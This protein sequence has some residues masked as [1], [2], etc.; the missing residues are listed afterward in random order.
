MG[1]AVAESWQVLLHKCFMNDFAQRSCVERP[2]DMPT[3]DAFMLYFR[4]LSGALQKEQDTCL[5]K[6]LGLY[7]V[8]LHSTESPASLHTRL[9]IILASAIPNSVELL[10]PCTGKD[11]PSKS[12][13]ESVIATTGIECCTSCMPSALQADIGFLAMCNLV[14]V[15][16]LDKFYFLL[17]WSRDCST[18]ILSVSHHCLRWSVLASQSLIFLL[19]LSVV[20]IPS[21]TT[22]PER[23][24]QKTNLKGTG[25]WCR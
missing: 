13:L 20:L 2:D 21:N 1:T 17:F 3:A 16:F 9:I 24:I 25:L 8:C 6:V 4:Y 11:T 7:Q 12:V 10:F 5:A 22:R 15:E 23:Q 18:D 19:S 14:S